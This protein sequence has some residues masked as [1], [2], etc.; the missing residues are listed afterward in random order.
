MHLSEI[1]LRHSRQTCKEIRSRESCTPSQQEFV[2]RC[3][4]WIGPA[5]GLCIQGDGD[6]FAN[7]FEAYGA[8]AKIALGF[9]DSFQSVR[10]GKGTETF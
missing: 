9:V 8:R 10:Y 1:S 5:A 2:I 7:D 3:E 4:E 6:G